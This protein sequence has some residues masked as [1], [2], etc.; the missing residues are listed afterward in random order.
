MPINS[1]IAHLIKAQDFPK[2]IGRLIFVR[3][4]FVA[5][6]EVSTFQQDELVGF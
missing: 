3:D 4:V 5:V 1:Q 6:L 2:N